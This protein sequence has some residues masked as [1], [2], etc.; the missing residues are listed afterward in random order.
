[1]GPPLAAVTL[2]A[3]HQSYSACTENGP[4]TARNSVPIRL[5]ELAVRL[6]VSTRRLL[7]PPRELPLLASVTTPAGSESR[8]SGRARKRTVDTSVGLPLESKPV[9]ALRQ[10]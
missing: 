10:E 7:F 8:I 9:C 5:D 4:R 2:L 1:M 3:V 6:P